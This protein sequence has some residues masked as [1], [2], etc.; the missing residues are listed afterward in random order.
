MRIRYFRTLSMLRIHSTTARRPSQISTGF[1]STH[2]QQQLIIDW[3][4]KLA[5]GRLLNIYLIVLY[6]PTLKRQQQR[7]KRRTTTQTKQVDRLVKSQQDCCILVLC[8]FL[9]TKKY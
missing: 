5:F 3:F 9:V 2:T 6:I 4:Y 8:H 1:T 7:R